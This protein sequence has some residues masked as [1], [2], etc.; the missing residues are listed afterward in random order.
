MGIFSFLNILNFPQMNELK[1]NNILIIE[2]DPEM[3]G[4]I[5]NMLESY[6]R[7]FCV[8]NSTDALKAL[9]SSTKFTHAF[10]DLDLE[11]KLA[12]LDIIDECLSQDIKC[13]VLSSHESKV[14]VNKCIA[15]GIHS[16]YD[17]VDYAENYHNI[18]AHF[19][20]IENTEIAELDDFF[21]YK[22][23]TTEKSI[24]EDVKLILSKKVSYDRVIQI[25][26]ETGTGKS[27]LAQLLH[28]ESDLE[29][30]FISFNV[31]DCTPSLM[32]SKLFG[33][34]DGAFTDSKGPAKGVFELANNGTLFLDEIGEMSLEMQKTLLLAIESKEIWPEGAQKPVKCNVRIIC[35][36]NNILEKLKAG[37]FRD[38]F[39]YRIND[40][41]VNIKPLNQRLEDIEI[42]A[43]N[44]ARE[45]SKSRGLGHASFTADALEVLKRYN[46]RGNSRE[47]RNEIKRI[48]DNIQSPLIQVSDLPEKFTTSIDSQE[49]PFP[50]EH[51]E[52]MM[53][54]GYKEYIKMVEKQ[55]IQRLIVDNKLSKY[56]ASKNLK[57]SKPVMNRLYDNFQ[58]SYE[59]QL[60]RL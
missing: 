53:E 55:I 51:Y 45:F 5:K 2:D 27:K 59:D 47:L 12:G 48:I 3:N 58:K 39:F 21:K 44:F 50:Q 46:W 32:K 13:A 43:A 60:C 8:Y 38:D 42:Q 7:C 25:V 30:K 33:H 14:I 29:G 28:E 37:K 20:G 1:K 35:A 36:G 6:G 4:H 16:Y 41:V 57:I 24:K 11:K 19:F 56:Q 34:V 18:N 15:K 49:F 10:I 23:M 9:K 26:G 22:Y 31:A 40:F 17:K 52:F 54:H